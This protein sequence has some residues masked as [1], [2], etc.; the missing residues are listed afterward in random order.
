MARQTGGAGS[1]EALATCTTHLSQIRGA[2]QMLGFEGV[3]RFCVSL[4][5]VVKS[6]QD[7]PACANKTAIAVVDRS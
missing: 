2:L 7:D 3:T 6:F 1:A 4:E 5:Q